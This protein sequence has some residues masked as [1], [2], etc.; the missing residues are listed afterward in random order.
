MGGAEQRDT[1]SPGAEGKPPSEETTEQAFQHAEKA[2]EAAG[3]KRTFDDTK[4]EETASNLE[5][6]LGQDA[7]EADLAALFLAASKRLGKRQKV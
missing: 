3:A 6:M 2:A 5:G 1:E 7:S 4:L